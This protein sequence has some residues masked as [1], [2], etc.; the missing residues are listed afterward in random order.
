MK[1][2]LNKV[3]N[4]LLSHQNHKITSLIHMLP[5]SQEQDFWI[6]KDSR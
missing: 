3:S 1:L 6:K 5:E 4:M 2:F